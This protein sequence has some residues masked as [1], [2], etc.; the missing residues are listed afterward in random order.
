MTNNQLSAVANPMNLPVIDQLTRATSDKSLSDLKNS[1]VFIYDLTRHMPPDV[2]KD[3]RDGILEAFIESGMLPKNLRLNSLS[4]DKRM[5]HFKTGADTL[6]GQLA[7]LKKLSTM[8]QLSRCAQ[9]IQCLT[10]IANH[11]G[12]VFLKLDEGVSNPA[13]CSNFDPKTG[14]LRF[15]LSEEKDK[16]VNL[17]RWVNTKTGDVYTKKG[18]TSEP[19]PTGPHIT[20]SSQD[21]YTIGS[22][23]GGGYCKG[24]I[25]RGS[26]SIYGKTTF[27]IQSLFTDRQIEQLP[28]EAAKHARKQYSRHTER[29]YTFDG[30][31]YEDRTGNGTLYYWELN[32]KNKSLSY[33]GDI[34]IDRGERTPV[35]HGEGEVT[36]RVGESY[37][38]YEIKGTFKNGRLKKFES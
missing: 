28:A 25:F 31:L 12:A 18:L 15:P 10:H 37:P 36:I 32:G 29:R 11:L 24:G 9:L 26:V 38:Y 20:M 35:P 17:T 14:F 34:K 6:F 7:E 30:N 33:Y 16:P 23:C 13:N 4:H 3:S 19:T 22:G 8:E 27:S 1:W 5:K 21:G 2:T